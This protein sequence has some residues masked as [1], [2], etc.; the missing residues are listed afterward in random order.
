MA[1]NMLR[2]IKISQELNKILKTVKIKGYYIP[3]QRSFQENKHKTNNIF[4]GYALWN[5]Y[6]KENQCL[7]HWPNLTY[8]FFEWN[9]ILKRYKVLCFFIFTM[10]V[11]KKWNKGSNLIYRSISP[12]NCQ[13]LSTLFNWSTI[14]IKNMSFLECPFIVAYYM[15]SHANYGSVSS[16]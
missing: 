13:P 1:G 7:P 8:T 9:E 6:S 10:R 5:A 11:G 4:D 14:E 15:A 12:A 3:F 2:L 16:R